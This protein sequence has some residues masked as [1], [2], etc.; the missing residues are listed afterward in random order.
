MTINYKIVADI[1]DI[2]NDNPRPSDIFLIDTN[3]LYWM[4]YTRASQA[5]P[6]PFPNQTITYPS[7]LSKAINTKSKLY[8]CGLSLAELAHIIEKNE[9]EIFNRSHTPVRTKEFRHNHS[10]EHNNV[11]TEIQSAWGQV[12]NFAISLDISID[13]STTDSALNKFTNHTVDGYD[14]F[15]IEAISKAGVVQIISDDGDFATVQGLQ[16]FTCNLNVIQ[17]A[18]QQGKL[19]IR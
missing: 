9:R 7:Y 15:T 17:A 19:V 14:L 5:I 2:T 8:R 12:K 11:V 10:S 4:T 6:P 1:I 13:E 18:R 3:V 16:V